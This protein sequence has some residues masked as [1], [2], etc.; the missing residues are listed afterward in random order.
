MLALVD[1]VH[2]YGCAMNPEH[3]SGNE[4][5]RPLRIAVIGGGLCGL[6]A[7]HRLTELSRDKGRACQVTVLEGEPVSGLVQTKS[8]EGYLVELGAD[9]FITNKAGA[10]ELCK[11][12]RLEGSLPSTD[13]TYRRSLVVHRGKPYAVPEGFQLLTPASIGSV[14]KSPLFSIAGKARMA[15]EPFVPKRR[16]GEDE[17]LVLFVKRRLGREALE[18]LVQPM[19]G[20][21]Y[22]SDP[23]RLSLRATM[24]RFLEME[25]KYGS[26]LKAMAAE[27]GSSEEKR[28]GA[29]CSLRIVC[30]TEEWDVGTCR[31]AGGAV[32]S[33]R[34]RDATGD[35][36]FKPGASGWRAGVSD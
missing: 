27:A 13:A 10:I 3:Q 21:I 34:C 8:V 22:T 20:G 11:R 6:A 19:V 16:S 30:R 9:S 12:I 24:P 7:A 32:E 28:G 25:Q 5:S 35:E 29:K 31:S 18:R 1:F 17:S 2:E 14:L 26:L 4:G 33:G 15:I 23:E 36:G